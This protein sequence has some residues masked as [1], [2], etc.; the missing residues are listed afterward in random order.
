MPRVRVTLEQRYAAVSMRGDQGPLAAVVLTVFKS[1]G[2]G[3]FRTAGEVL[4]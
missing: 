2:R 3:S 4:L 1:N